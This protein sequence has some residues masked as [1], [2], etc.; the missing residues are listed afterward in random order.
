MVSLYALITHSH[1]PPLLHLHSHFFLRID[2]NPSPSNVEN[3]SQHPSTH[4]NLDRRQPLYHYDIDNLPSRH[5]HS[6]RGHHSMMMR[7]LTY[8]R[9]ISLS[10]ERRTGPHL[11]PDYGSH[12]WL[13][14]V[15]ALGKVN[16]GH[17]SGW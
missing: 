3:D 2:F 15:E 5:K 11:M 6:T 13:G 16:N 14:L 8:S 17:Q 9:F 12:I 7:Y 10:F 4:P 1:I